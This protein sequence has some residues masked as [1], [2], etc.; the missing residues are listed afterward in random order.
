MYYDW[1]LQEDDSN[2][3]DKGTQPGPAKDKKSAS[4]IKREKK[5]ERKKRKEEER[6]ANLQ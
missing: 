1:L 2:K 3:K 4:Q 6:K 5:A